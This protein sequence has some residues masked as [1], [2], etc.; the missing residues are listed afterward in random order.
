M[1]ICLATYKDRLASLF[2]NATQL[3]MYI[4]ENKSVS[5]A[6]EI[7]FPEKGSS[8]RISAMI[9]CGVDIL[10]CGALCKNT[11]QILSNHNIEVLDWRRGNIKEVLDAWI[12]NRTHQLLMPGCQ[13]QKNYCKNPL[14]RS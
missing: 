12:Y 8:A 7:S 6:G 14:N 2:E 10:I 13:K 9:A 4:Y 1:K 3:Q 11:K 5:S